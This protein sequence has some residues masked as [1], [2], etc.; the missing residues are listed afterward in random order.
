MCPSATLS[1]TNPT[2][3]EESSN[4][5]LYGELTFTEWETKDTME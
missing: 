5:W 2:W 4:L 1:T 3:I